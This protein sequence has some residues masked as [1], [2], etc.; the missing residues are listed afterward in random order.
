MS[1]TIVPNTNIIVSATGKSA[2]SILDFL[3][4]TNPLLD[5]QVIIQPMARTFGIHYTPKNLKGSVP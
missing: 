1:V 5:L 4:I 3:I 2:M